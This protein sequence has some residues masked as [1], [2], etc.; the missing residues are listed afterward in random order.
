MA[1]KVE[2]RLEPENPG[3]TVLR[4]IGVGLK[5]IER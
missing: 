3:G 1:V 5:R 2:S 4:A